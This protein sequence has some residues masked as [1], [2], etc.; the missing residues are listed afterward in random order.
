MRNRIS[1]IAAVLIILFISVGCIRHEFHMLAPKATSSIRVDFDW[2]GFTDIPPGMNLMF[3]PVID[4]STR[5]EDYTGKP[6]FHQIQ[7]DGGVIYLPNGK[8]EAVIYNDYTYS[9]QF[10]GMDAHYSAEAYL[11]EVSRAPLSRRSPILYSVDAPDIL[12]TG[13]IETLDVRN[14]DGER[15]IIVKPVLRTLKVFVHV[16]IDGIHNVS[17]A[18]GS[19][20]GASEGVLLHSGIP[21]NDDGC[22]RI[23]Q[24]SVS[25]EELYASTTMFV[26]KDPT[27]T[28]YE[29]ELAFLLRNNS[30]KVGNYIYDVSDQ[31]RRQ[32]LECEGL[33]PPHGIHVYVDGVR[34]EDV[35][36]GG[37]DASIDGWGDVIDIELN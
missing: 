21:T 20:T 33:L 36:S 16:A 11:A 25:D 2:D 32:L 13:H 31:I 12:Y 24:F 14:E 30:V 29:L 35:A 18:D 8:Y 37:L 26:S 7:F 23:F 3:Y 1:L 22:K 10:R 4:E 15:H 34:I 27:K 17:Q 28:H 6:I 5:E 19:I 9:L